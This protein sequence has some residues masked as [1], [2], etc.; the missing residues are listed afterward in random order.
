M[1][2]DDA[3]ELVLAVGPTLDRLVRPLE[4]GGAAHEWYRE[5]FVEV[6][7]CRVGARPV[8]LQRG[9]I[10]GLLP[11]GRATRSNHL[12]WRHPLG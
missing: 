1:D 6:V 8:A 11:S 7:R 2:V 9:R 5:Q 10:G 4:P 12:R 3:D